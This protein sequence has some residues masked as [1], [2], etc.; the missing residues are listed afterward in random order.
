[1]P[2]NSRFHGKIARYDVIKIKCVDISHL[3]TNY[4]EISSSSPGNPG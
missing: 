4:V 1:M 2:K 3:D